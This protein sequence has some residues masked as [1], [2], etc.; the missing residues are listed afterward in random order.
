MSGYIVCGEWGAMQMAPGDDQLTW[1]DKYHPVTIFPTR[2][3]ALG[4]IT[5]SNNW[6]KKN[7]YEPLGSR[8]H[9][10]ARVYRLADTAALTP[11]ASDHGAPDEPVRGQSDLELPAAAT[12]RRG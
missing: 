3:A 10:F 11:P 8:G 2:K 7:G 1:S 4:A 5:R 12:S 9:N 6:R